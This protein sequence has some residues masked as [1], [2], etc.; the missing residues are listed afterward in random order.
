MIIK[1][2][3]FQPSMMKK[4]M[5]LDAPPGNPHGR[6]VKYLN[7]LCAFDIET[8]TKEDLN[9]MYIWQFQIDRDYTVIGRTWTEFNEFTD[10]LITCIRNLSLVCYVFNLSYEFQYLKGL[11]QFNSDTVF[12]T[13]RRKVLKCIFKDKIEFRCAYFLT[14]MSL[15]AFTHKMGVEHGKLSGE[16]FD[17]S[18]IRYPWTELSDSELQYCINDVVGLVEAIQKQME[19]D[20]DNLYTIPLTSTG[21]P[22]RDMKYSM[23][24]YSYNRIRKLQPS[25]EV[26]TLLR[27]A[28]RGGN[29]HANRYYAG[30]LIE[31]VISYDR[32]SSYP[33]VLVNCMFPMT[34]FE[35]EMPTPQMVVKHISEGDAVIFSVAFTDIHLRNTSWGC[36]YLSTDKCRSVEKAIHDNG[37]IL[38]AD[39]LETTLTD[40]DFRILLSE[41]DFE[42]MVIGQCYWSR[43]DY[44]PDQITSVIKSYYYDKTILKGKTDEFSKLMYDKSKALL[45]GLYGLMAQDICKRNIIFDGVNFDYADD[46]PIEQL[47]KNERKAFLAYQWGVWCTSWARYRLEEGIQIA[48]TV[49]DSFVYCDTDSVKFV[50]CGQDWSKYNQERMNDSIKNR[51]YAVDAK[52]HEHYMGVF[53][54]DGKYDR[55]ITLGAKRYAYEDKDGLHITVSGVGKKAGAKELGCIENFKDGF[56]F[57]HGGKTESMYCDEPERHLI[58]VDGHELEITPYVVI[59]D[60]TYH[61][62]LSDEYRNL[63]SLIAK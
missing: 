27:Q 47:Q 8:S 12:A 4:Y 63:L 41:Y 28:F 20:G 59:R 1:A 37:R 23:R 54:L 32:S 46:D 26:Y 6:R 36:P 24:K 56:T 10:K 53:E 39:Y 14:N 48:E 5:P 19:R 22:R 49:P 13:D 42:D 7:C 40:I 34:P 43:Y 15:N 57:Y 9:W 52:G 33:D 29:T 3:Q 62:G 21:Y 31:N 17:Y 25:F 2:D 11:Y 55:F 61:L 58:T 35:Y 60:T 51:A 50:D 38:S 45:N 30:K 44:L 18:I 16:E